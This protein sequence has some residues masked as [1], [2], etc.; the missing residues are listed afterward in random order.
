MYQRCEV[1]V[2]ASNLVLTFMTCYETVISMS[3]LMLESPDYLSKQLITYFGN[4]RKLLPFIGKMVEQI[5]SELTQEKVS[6]LD[7]FSGSGVVSRM[8]KQHSNILH[9]NDMGYYASVL[10]NCYLANKD[11]VPNQELEAHI[12][13]LKNAVHTPC[14]GFVQELYAPKNDKDIKLG[15]R[16]FFTTQNARSI[17]ACIQYIHSPKVPKVLFPFLMAPLLSQVTSHANMSGGFRGFYRNSKTKIGQFGGDGENSL[18]RIM[19][20][21]EIN[22]PIFSNFSCNWRMHN[23][24]TNALI[25]ALDPVD[26]AYFDPPYNELPYGACYSMLDLIAKNERPKNITPGAGVP[27][28]WA[29]SGYNSKKEAEGLIDDLAEHTKAKYVAMSYSNEGHVSSNT[30]FS[31]LSKHGVVTVLEQVYSAFTASRNWKGRDPKVTEMIFL[32]KKC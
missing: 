9:S 1:I 5:K 3:D 14:E 6:I 19:R 13:E 29:R 7:G 10:G 16:A 27:K 23:Q 22:Y 15:E 17:D 24:D 32:L 11:E 21:I 18:Q 12:R 4:K 31:V 26:L 20:P 8:L 2:N 30:V 25:K 28:N